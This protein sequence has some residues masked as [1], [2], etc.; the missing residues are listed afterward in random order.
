MIAVQLNAFRLNDLEIVLH[1][2]TVLNVMEEVE[3]DVDVDPAERADRGFWERKASPSFLEVIDNIVANLRGD[4]KEPRI[5]YNRHHI[6]MGT[7]G[8]NFCWFHPR[9]R[10]GNCHIECRLT[11]D[12]R[13][14]AV[15]QLQNEGI[16][17]SPIRTDNVAFIV[18]PATLAA[19]S[20]AIMDVLKRAEEASKR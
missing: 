11:S 5:T 17:A 3:D 10:L 6:A 14:E 19:H 8:Y 1:P 13:D 9:T 7:T 20:T 2:V 4:G 15:T 18:T 16:D 12:S